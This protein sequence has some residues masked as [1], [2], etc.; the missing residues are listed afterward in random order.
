M[1]QP[2][3]NREG[4]KHVIC[5]DSYN[6]GILKGWFFTPHQEVEHFSSL[7]QFLYKM[8]NLLDQL[9]SP[10]AYTTLRR[11][12]EPPFDNTLPDIVPPKGAAATFDLQILF[13]QHTS[14]QG[15]LVWREK[16]AEHSFRS[17][18][19]LILLLDSALRD[20]EGS[21]AA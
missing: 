6:E 11:F 17:V 4:R 10:Q 15:T 9:Q 7:S 1:I 14:W 12:S 3:W 8:D 18:L 19:E 2:A 5:V 20:E 21:G 16:R 13:R